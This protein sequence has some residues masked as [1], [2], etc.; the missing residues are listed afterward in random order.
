MSWPTL[1]FVLTVVLCL[2]LGQA[3]ES[4]VQPT[5]SLK[6][7]CNLGDNLLTNPGGA[8]GAVDVSGDKLES[9]IASIFEDKVNY[10][11]KLFADDAAT[12]ILEY[13]TTNLSDL[14]PGPLGNFSITQLEHN[15]EVDDQVEEDERGE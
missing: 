3:L 10:S 9:K 5:C 14:H 7:N 1:V 15:L 8:D 12:T 13:Q 11:L 2:G 6:D 4:V